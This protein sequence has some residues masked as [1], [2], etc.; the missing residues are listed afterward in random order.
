M[1]HCLPL[2]VF[3]LAFLEEK[4]EK[5]KFYQISVSYLRI[6]RPLALPEPEPT[7]PFGLSLPEPT[8][9]HRPDLPYG[10]RQTE[11]EYTVPF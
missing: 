11:P 6:G 3:F 9:R 5:I 1:P 8:Y 10:S 7:R 2:H 4:L